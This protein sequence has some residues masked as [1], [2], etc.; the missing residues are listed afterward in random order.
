MGKVHTPNSPPPVAP[1]VAPATTTNTTIL[2]KM[3]FSLK[4]KIQLAVIIFFVLAIP[5]VCT[6]SLT[7]LRYD[8]SMEFKTY[9]QQVEQLRAQL[10]DMEARLFDAQRS[11]LIQL[12]K[13]I[14]DRLDQ[15]NQEKA[16][17]T[18]NPVY[19][20]TIKKMKKLDDAIIICHVHKNN[21][22]N[23]GKLNKEEINQL[24][25]KIKTELYIK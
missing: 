6:Y 22:E 3:S 10:H 25:Q 14:S 19:I 1:V 15:Y 23:S 24:I 20:E 17:L 9:T 11:E 18:N 5:V 16:I 7:K 13:V 2:Q 21:I 12:N 8:S 4:E